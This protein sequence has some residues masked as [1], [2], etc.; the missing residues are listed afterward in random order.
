MTKVSRIVYLAAS[1]LFLV[2]VSLQVFLAGMVVVALRTGWGNHR[3]L[4]HALAL[5]LL[6][7]LVTA[8]LGR[9]PSKIKWMTWLLLGVYIIQAD[10]II[11][12]R[13]SYPYVSAFHPVL[14]LVDFGLGAFL[15]YQV[16]KLV[17]D[18]REERPIPTKLVEA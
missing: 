6:I 13:A 3:G 10:V 12:M 9:L 11:F 14:A 1:T 2:G 16:W 18:D 15:V 5:P 17:Q 7:M 4:G 8:Y